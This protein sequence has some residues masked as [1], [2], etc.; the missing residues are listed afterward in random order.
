MQRQIIQVQCLNKI[1]DSKDYSFIED[2]ML[3]KEEFVGYE[4]EFEYIDN[5]YKQYGNIPDKVSFLSQFPD[6]DL[7]E[8]Q[9]SDRYLVETLRE[10]NLFSKLVPVLQE[11][12][13]LSQKD[14]NE[15]VRYMYQ[16]MKDLEPNYRLGGT[17]IVANAE[18]RY[19]QFIERKEHQDTW[20][21]TS[22]FEELD[23]L[24]HG[25]QREEE[26]FVIVARTNQGKSWVIGKICTH[27][28]QLGFNVGFISPEMG[29]MSV[30]YRFDTLYKNFSNKAL[31]WG[32]EDVEEEEYKEYI[33]DLEKHKNKFMVATPNDFDRKM[34]ITKLKNWIKQYKLD[35]LAIDGIT[36]LQD[37]R[38]KKGDNKTTTLTNISEDLMSLS[39]EMHVPILVVV[40]ANRDATKD[41]SA[42][43]PELET[44]RDSDGIAMNASK[45]ISIQQS[46]DGILKM[47]IKKQRF[48]PVGGK[49]LWS[50]DIDRGEFMF[51]PS[52]DDA[53]SMEKTE[54]KVED[55]K[56]IYKDKTDA[57]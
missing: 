41:K 11:T 21:F 43:T 30:G 51:V 31:M 45:V 27:I 44:I 37:E 8:V 20:F 12:V 42:S 52:Y 24:I 9:E 55:V 4:K 3:A 39:M 23:D 1:L 15:A 34:T 35:I 32:R 13:N 54:R 36:Y 56:R 50:W 53:E 25:I 2:N 48:G 14:S 22:G 28:W 47:E 29:A 46:K 10:E 7:V 57:F 17:D 6:F 40:Q 38:G 5:H 49:L 18:D 19:N 16:A 33:Q 26:L